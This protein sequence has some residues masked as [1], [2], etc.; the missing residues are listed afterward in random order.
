MQDHTEDHSKGRLHADIDALRERFTETRALYKEVCGLLFFRYGITPTAN[1]L[2]NLVKKGSMGTPGEVLQLFW[3]ELRDRSRVKIEHPDLPDPLKQVAADAVQGIWSV[4]VAAAQNELAALRVDARRVAEEAEERSQRAEA[5]LER[6]IDALEHGQAALTEA[7]QA[8][9]TMREE[10]HA[11]RKAH[12]ATTARL[13]EARG[14]VS[15]RDQQMA[16]ARTQFDT[17]LAHARQQIQL[18]QDRE[19]DTTRRVML[20][21]D[22]ER[23]ARK[24]SEAKLDKLRLELSAVQ[25]Q[26]HDEG[27]RHVEV[28]GRQQVELQRLTLQ[29]TEANN[30][31]AGLGTEL[32]SLAAARD[33][34]IRRAELAEAEVV[35]TRRLVAE[36]VTREQPGSPESGP[37]AT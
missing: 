6:V 31:L 12:A 17:D 29:L 22:R 34:A 24:H 8:L 14:Q 4:A 9:V 1:M 18:A 36:L 15:E 2:Y 3:Q 30:Q 35:L 37:V 20:D 27:L 32:A 5:E 10:L 13:E 11:E 23:T 26:R 7:N 25:Q 28:S 16:A 19:A 21:F 33:S